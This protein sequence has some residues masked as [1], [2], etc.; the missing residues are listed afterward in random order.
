VSPPRA[1]LGQDPGLEERGDDQG[2]EPDGEARDEP[3]D[4]PRAAA[5][6]PEEPEEERRREQRDGLEGLQADVHEAVELADGHREEV[7]EVDHAED[8][9][10]LD[11]E[12]D[13]REAAVPWKPISAGI[14]MLF[15]AMVLRARDSTM[16]MLVAA[17]KPPRKTIMERYFIPC[18]SGMEST[19]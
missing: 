2:V 1:P 8:D 15:M 6:L 16:T 7:A 9:Q 14:T 19:K 12:D 5:A 13:R 11:R 3:G 18:P 17:E 4:G 10:A